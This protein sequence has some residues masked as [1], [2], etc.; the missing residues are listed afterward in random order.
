[1]NTTDVIII[2]GGPAGLICCFWL[3][4]MGIPHLLIEKENYP[5]DKVC[6][7]VLTSNAIRRINEIDEHFIPEL[8][9]LGLLR[10]IFGTDVSTSLQHSI[11]LQFHY[12]D[13]QDGVPSCYSIQRKELDNY[14]F[15]KLKH[16]LTTTLTG[17]EV[18]SVTIKESFAEVITSDNTYQSKLVLIASGSNF[19]PLS[20][21]V[22]TDDKHVAVGIRAYFTD[23]DYK[24]D[25]CEL[26][27]DPRIIPGGVYIAPLEK[28]LFNVNMVIRADVVR[29]KKINLRKEL[30]YLMT[31]N[32]LLKHRFKN[33]KRVTDFTGSSL[34]L[35][36]K[37]RPISG[38]RYL[39]VGDSAGLI[40]LISAN[41]IPQAMLSG[42]LAAE[43][44]KRCIDA[45]DF[46]AQATSA[47]ADILFKRINSDLAVGK[48]INPFLHYNFIQ[49]AIMQLVYFT[50]K[51]STTNSALSQLL[52]A[53]HPVWLL[54]NPLFY[55]KLLKEI[56]VPKKKGV[57]G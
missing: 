57:V 32:A 39:L 49:K 6:A 53:K 13:H 36:T 42:K 19:N 41:G 11:G 55:F 20:A 14:L 51:S 12:L 38:D 17:C 24:A 4:K 9:A 23:V 29:K 10:P 16:P 18:K 46:S 54:F 31:H 48:L 34:L 26:I 30:D 43:Q 7:D 45:N 50:T 5:R 28:G 1:M 33:A 2:G 21:P 35:G 8:I 27:L 56:I 37:R 52:Y 25:Y 22:K 47:Y 3:Q 44:V 40:D 15:Q